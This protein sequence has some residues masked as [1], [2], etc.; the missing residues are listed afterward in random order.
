MTFRFRKAVVP[1]DFSEEAEVA[2]EMA[3]QLAE[4]IDLVHVVEP[5]R[6]LP[7][8]VM[9]SL[10]RNDSGLSAKATIEARKATPAAHSGSAEPVMIMGSLPPSSRFAGMS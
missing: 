5:E 3:A 7:P 9:T 2:I 6:L 1:T 4:A 10:E 8:Y